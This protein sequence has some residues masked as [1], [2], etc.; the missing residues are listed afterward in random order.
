MENNSQIKILH[1]YS[2]EGNLGDAIRI[3]EIK[4]WLKKHFDYASLNLAETLSAKITPKN[5][6]TLSKGVAKGE[7][8]EIIRDKVFLNRCQKTIEEKL[9]KSNFDFI[10]AEMAHVGFASIQ[11]AKETQVKVISDLHGLTSAEYIENKYNKKRNKAYWQFLKK[12]EKEVY[13]K[14]EALVCVS[15]P[16]ANYIKETAPQAKTLVAQNGTQKSKKKAR[17]TSPLKIIYGGIFA[18]WEDLN[19]FLNMAKLDQKNNYFLMGDGPEKERLLDR[20]KKERIKIKYLGSKKRDEA[21]K[22]FAKMNIGMAPTSTGLTRQVASPIKIYDYMSFGLPAITA[23]C[24]EWGDQIK[25]Y[26][27]G[28]VTKKSSGEQF[29]TAL[30]K[31]ENKENWSKISNNALALAKEKTWDNILEKNLTKVF[32]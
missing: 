32:K 27:A 13:E 15:G 5:L 7:I 9:K 26:G 23:K 1:V 10:F 22:I 24:G 20:V 11:T 25:E 30:K 4:K 21:H 18:F 6:Q 2:V 28:V 8:K 14:S 19:T 29:Y 3:N 12:I 31:L 16:M 17:F